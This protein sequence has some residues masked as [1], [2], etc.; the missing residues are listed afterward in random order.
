MARSPLRGLSVKAKSGSLECAT[1]RSTSV[2]D[3]SRTSCSV[4]CELVTQLVTTR[5]HHTQL[6]SEEPFYARDPDGL[7][8]EVSWLVPADML[9]LETGGMKTMP[10]NL[11][12][13]IEQFGAET[14]GG[15]GVSLHKLLGEKTLQ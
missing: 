7:E 6:K 10:L 9:H 1:P 15:V 12:I 11:M 14:L 2:D 13:T 3:G 4:C 8:F 5:D